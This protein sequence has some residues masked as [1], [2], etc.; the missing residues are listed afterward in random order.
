M[1]HYLRS[2]VF[3]QNRDKFNTVST[4]RD[5]Y[6]G[7]YASVPDAFKPD[8][9]GID[10]SGDFDFSTMYSRTFDGPKMERNLTKKQAAALLNE[11]RRRKGKHFVSSAPAGGGSLNNLPV[12]AEC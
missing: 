3:M 6:K 2:E 12:V 5:T 11:L 10:K 1:Q 8:A 9:K 4:T 7:A